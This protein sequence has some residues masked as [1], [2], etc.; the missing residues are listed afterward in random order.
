[1]S[2]NGPSSDRSLPGVARR[3]QSAEDT[4]RAIVAAARQAFARDGYADTAL[5]AIVG[6]AGLTKGALYHH[7]KN[8][9]AVLE[10]VYIE[11]VEELAAR[12]KAAVST[13]TGGA[14]DRI[15][16]AVDAFFAVSA[17]PEY[18][19]VVLRETP[20]VLGATRG[21][22]IDQAIGLGLVMQLITELR[23]EGEIRPLPIA[24][25]ARVVLAAASEVAVAMSQADDPE[26]VRKEGTEVMFALL[27]GLRIAPVVPNRV[28]GAFASER[29]T[30][31]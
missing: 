10:A 28:T 22:E 27:E 12:V 25:T 23:N 11:M 16:A 13:S 15:V 14:W 5:E 4:R 9:A 20:A 1:M 17:E 19:R 6:P 26:R 21:R 7:F 3:E 24:A 30:A 31:E 29:T 8:K 2:S 18:M